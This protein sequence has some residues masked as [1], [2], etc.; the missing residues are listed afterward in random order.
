MYKVT[1]LREKLAIIMS[2]QLSFLVTDNLGGD[3]GTSATIALGIV[4]LCLPDPHTGC[5]CQI[6]QFKVVQNPLFKN[7]LIILNTYY[8]V[9]MWAI[10]FFSLQ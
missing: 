9:V 3:D 6:K 5:L 10:W 1:R 4:T 7:V 2:C 8:A